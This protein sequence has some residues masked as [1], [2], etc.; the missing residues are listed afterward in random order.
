[1]KKLKRESSK[2]EIQAGGAS[3]PRVKGL[4][5]SASQAVLRANS[6]PTAKPAESAADDI[7]VR[8][9]S[10]N[11]KATK[12]G[13]DSDESPTL[14]FADEES[15]PTESSSDDAGSSSSEEKKTKKGEKKSKEKGSVDG[16][17]LAKIAEENSKLLAQVSFFPLLNALSLSDSN[18]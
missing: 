18:I 13:S 17:M 12:E 1:M 11:K 4:Q 10:T 9:Q 2:R 8:K 5:R 16:A 15:P 14:F 7:A 3:K 6:T